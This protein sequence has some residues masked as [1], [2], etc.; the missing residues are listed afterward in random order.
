MNIEYSQFLSINTM[1]I[2]CKPVRSNKNEK[3][4]DTMSMVENAVLNL[5]RAKLNSNLDLKN[6]KE[7]PSD[8]LKEFRDIPYTNRDG[9]QLL[10]VFNE[11]HQVAY[12]VFAT[13]ENK[14]RLEDVLSGIAGK[15]VPV[16]LKLEESG[17][18]RE[19]EY[20]DIIQRFGKDRGLEISIE[21]DF[22]DN[23]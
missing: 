3:R 21:D 17:K 2:K 13:E 22:D 10:I 7:I 19:D 1:F 15:E 14:K 9:K 20:E 23:D 6:I 5:I 18:R 12:N 11:E 8:G 16:I 4:V